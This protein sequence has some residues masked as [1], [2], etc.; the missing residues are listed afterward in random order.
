VGDFLVFA[1]DVAKW[2]HQIEM[3]GYDYVRTVLNYILTNLEGKDIKSLVDVAKQQ[4]TPKMGDEIMTFAD[5]ARHEG[6]QQGIEQGR[7]QIRLTA[8]KLLEKGLSLEMIAETTGLTISEIK[9]LSAEEI[10]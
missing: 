9:N 4:L 5:Q 8:K 10:V 6:F 2:L 3:E 7:Q 1:E